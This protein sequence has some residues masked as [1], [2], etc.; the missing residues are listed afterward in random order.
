M[1]KIN[2]FLLILSTLCISNTFS[3]EA[4]ISEGNESL[5]KF[6]IPLSIYKSISLSDNK[7][8]YIYDSKNILMPSIKIKKENKYKENSKIKE[9]KFFI[10]E[11]FIQKRINQ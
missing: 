1:K 3:Y 8:L 2:I 10:K 11:E 4:R 6:E 7:N 9:I 5:R